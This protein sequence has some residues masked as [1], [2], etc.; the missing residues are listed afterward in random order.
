MA[1]HAFTLATVLLAVVVAVAAVVLPERV[2]VHLGVGLTADR[3]GT[4]TEFLL[5]AGGT[6]L[7][8]AVLFPA[9]TLLVRRVPLRALRVP[10]ERYW[11]A[12]ERRPELRRRLADDLWQ[13]GAGTTL[14]LAGE[15]ALVTAAGVRGADELSPWAVVLLV[16]Y[17][18]GVVGWLAWLVT[19]RY[20]PPGGRSSRRGGTTP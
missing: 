13:L 17:L 5:V 7:G 16:A 14:L 19:G 20:R 8:L 18:G 11:Q 3:Y 10:Y 4:R 12:P 15:F 9:L 2:P 1:R 6:A